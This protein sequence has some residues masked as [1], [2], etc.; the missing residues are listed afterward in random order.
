MAESHK[1]QF[2]HLMISIFSP[3]DKPKL[4]IN[5]NRIATLSLGF[6]DLDKKYNDYKIFSKKDAYSIF[7]F[8]KQNKS[9]KNIVIHCDAG[10][11]RSPAI[12]AALAKI[13]NFDDL[14]YFKKY[15]PNRLVYRTMLDVWCDRVGL[16]IPYTRLTR[17]NII[18][19]ACIF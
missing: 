1:F 4:P 7:E 2:P 16:K 13:F 17:K 14:K 19:K 8:L 9:T 3:N 11:A 15:L 5:K 12:A 10:I 6:H 18:N